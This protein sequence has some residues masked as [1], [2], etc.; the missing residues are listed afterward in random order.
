MQSASSTPVA[1]SIV[2]LIVGVGLTEAI[3]TGVTVK[4]ST[5]T[6]LPCGARLGT[7]LTPPG[8]PATSVTVFTVGM[9]GTSTVGDGNTGVN[10][11][12]TGDGG[13]NVA[14]GRVGGMVGAAMVAGGTVAG[15]TVGGSGVGD[16]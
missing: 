16:A 9:M 11:G 8:V 14:G 1:P 15:G 3:S 10:V 4:A 2:G 7:R 5:G 13:T 6:E 12:G